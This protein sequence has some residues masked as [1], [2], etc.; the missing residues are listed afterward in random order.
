MCLY[1][2]FENGDMWQVMPVKQMIDNLEFFLQVV[3]WS[4]RT[5]ASGDIWFKKNLILEN[6]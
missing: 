6:S 5:I 3:Q 1:N 2:L 4:L